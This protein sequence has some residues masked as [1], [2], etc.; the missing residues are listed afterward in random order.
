MEALQRIH[1]DEG[2]TKKAVVFGGS[3]ATSFIRKISANEAVDGK[4]YSFNDVHEL[5]MEIHS[6]LCMPWGIQSFLR[7]SS[8]AT[9]GGE[10]TTTPASR[11]NYKFRAYCYWLEERMAILKENSSDPIMALEIAAAA[12]YGLTRLELHPF[13]NGNGRTARALVNAILMSYSYE[14]TAH[15]LAVPPVPILR[16]E[17]KGADAYIKALRSVRKT[18]SLNPFMVFLAQRWSENLKERLEK[19]RVKIGIPKARGDKA[20]VE[21]LE[22][23]MRLL[24]EFVHNAGVRLAKAKIKED[25]IP[26]YQIYPIPEYAP[27][28][29]AGM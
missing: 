15:H 27:S 24:G 5:I 1:V 13:D 21:V 12:H 16:D 9:V 17:S 4:K 10:L 25:K 23:R 3:R 18:N 29:F 28:R 11:L 6:R 8:S 26:T 19:I 20:L 22:N 7:E 14:L 2:E